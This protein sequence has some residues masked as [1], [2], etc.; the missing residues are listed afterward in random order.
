MINVFDKNPVSVYVLDIKSFDTTHSF[1]KIVKQRIAWANTKDKKILSA[2]EKEDYK[3]LKK[4]YINIKTGG[5]E[6]QEIEDI[7]FDD[8]DMNMIDNDAQVAIA[9]VSIEEIKEYVIVSD[10]FIFP[11]DKITDFKNK[12]F[13]ATKIPPYRQHIF[14]EHGKN[15][16]NVGYQI[17]LRDGVII[18]QK[19]NIQSINQHTTFHEGLPVD[20]KWYQKKNNLNVINNNDTVLL[21][22][23]YERHSA[24]EFY[25]V[26]LNDFINPVRGSIERLLKT[27]RYSVELIYYSFVMKYWPQVQLSVLGDMVINEEILSSK[28][29]ELAPVHSSIKARYIEE[30]KLLSN[31]L[32]EINSK[33]WDVPI[34]VSIKNATVILPDVYVLA[35]YN[36]NLRNIF[37]MYEL[38]PNV[39]YIIC[40]TEI[41]GRAIILSKGY[42][43]T[44]IPRLKTFMNT[45][46]INIQEQNIGNIHFIL[47]SNGAYRI[48][49]WLNEHINYNFLSI[50]DY[51]FNSVNP[52]IEKINTFGN[53]AHTGK[54]PILTE[55]NYTFSNINAYALWKLNLSSNK[56]QEVK[57]ILDRYVMSGIL[58]KN[59]TEA[60]PNKLDYYFIKGMNK[61]SLQFYAS[62]PDTLNQYSYLTNIN[63][64]R[65]YESILYKK[66][67][68]VTHR[69]TD[70]RIDIS[71]IKDREYVIF[72]IYMLRLCES[73]PRENENT[74]STDSKK[75]RMLKERDPNLFDMK[76][77]YGSDLV[78]AK[79]CQ[80]QKQPVIY[81]VPGKKRIQYWNMTTNIPNY[82]ECPNPMYPYLNFIT[83]VHPK[84]FCL[85]CCYKMPVPD[86]PTNKKTIRY[87]KCM[88]EKEYDVIKKTISR[89]RYV[90]TY[91]KP[92]EVGRISRLPENSLEPLL[93]D[94]FTE[95]KYGTDEECHQ[96][97][98]YYIFGV[99][100]NF[101]NVTKIGYIFSI[102]NA[103]NRNVIDFVIKTIQ[104]I[105]ENPVHWVRILNG[106]IIK[107]F[108]NAEEFISEINSVFVDN[109]ISTLKVWNEI[110]IDVASIY[111]HVETIKCIDRIDSDE[112]SDVHITTR[113][114]S[115]ISER[116][117]ENYIVVIYKNASVYP[118][119]SL[120]HDEYFRNGDVKKK[121]FK[122]TDL[123][124]DKLQGVI[125]RT[126]KTSN[127]G[128]DIDSYIIRKFIEQ[129]DLY[130]IRSLYINSSNTC[131]GMAITADT[132]FFIP[133]MYSEYDL[134]TGYELLSN[135]PA[136][137]MP[138]W[139]VMEKFI[140]RFNAF[141][142][143][144]EDAEYQPIKIELW[145]LLEG[146]TESKKQIVGFISNNI[147]YI[148]QPITEKKA[149]SIEDVPYTRL[150]YD[151]N[152]VNTSLVMDAPATPDYRSANIDKNLYDK[153]L[154]TLLIIEFI[155]YI[156]NQRNLELRGNILSFIAEKKPLNTILDKYPGDLKKI[157]QV[158]NKV[159]EKPKNKASENEIYRENIFSIEDAKKIIDSSVFG[160]D[161]TQFYRMSNMNYN[162]VLRELIS[163]FDNITVNEEPRFTI[164]F[165]NIMTPCSSNSSYCNNGKL[166]VKKKKLHKILETMAHDVL[167]PFKS[168]YI[169]NPIFTTNIINSFK[170]TMRKDENITITLL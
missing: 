45:M 140:E 37:D 112:L 111:W 52:V 128:N 21:G 122:S 126:L 100:Q 151:P 13:I 159:V 88:E 43:D 24:T 165:P 85:P 23:I 72:Y 48:D 53:Y 58:A 50:R 96:N 121:V 143:T 64:K 18:N 6:E 46:I 39:D 82:Y 108:A 95:N 130:T 129:D 150:L 169:F 144:Y 98:G 36:A 142:K 119:Y 170:M 136:D 66:K 156:G 4:R 16:Y 107:Y 90:I 160:F 139:A 12:I 57:R 84:K 63:T 83:G 19:I 80:Q 8:E 145:L 92:V 127:Q 113:N 138:T 7:I 22:D 137:L 20:N 30:T 133:V 9:P 157:E 102:S 135:Y 86:D 62:S 115:H 123:I 118:I 94:T 41:D 154:Y 166:M 162:D 40:M 55:N 47:Y 106:D 65:L 15:I 1:S 131:Y 134:N 14:Y 49:I 167:N 116:S 91:G 11:E 161:N 77:V 148:I 141:I 147:N 60:L 28:Y 93:Y 87:N 109:K 67:L 3:E 99:S 110:F 35:G 117:A 29:P 2:W 105:E 164:E 27:D 153:Y 74:V 56:F 124:V 61:Y 149:I 163:I 114:I 31:Y 10:I 120:K 34:V 17:N 155:N 42:R 54:I 152:E 51:L 44:V 103:L 125:D 38:T 32:P 71:G 158:I 25:V 76:A 132:T 146:I 69:F 33:K 73:F 97:E 70:I 5:D 59:T 168:K 104:K 79:I 89:S 81:D 101:N 75:L 68:S 78:Y 26:D